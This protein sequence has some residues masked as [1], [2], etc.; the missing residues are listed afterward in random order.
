M[1][2][3]VLTGNAGRDAE[4]KYSQAGNAV[5]SFSLAEY[6]GQD[7]DAVWWDVVCFGKTAEAA[8]AMVR[9]G[10]RVTAAGYTELDTWEKD[11][12]TRSRLK[13]I[14]NAIGAEP[15]KNAAGGSQVPT[16]TNA[17][18]RPAMAAQ[19]APAQVAPEEADPFGDQ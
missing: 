14:A 1:N 5:C 13:L 10:D 12:Q 19:S 4:L 17:A 15:P 2:T 11:G 16:P 9:K 8:A 7:K 3:Q 18:Q 6:K